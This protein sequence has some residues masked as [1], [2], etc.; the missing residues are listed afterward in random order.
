M[1]FRFI[2]VMGPTE[3]IDDFDVRSEGKKE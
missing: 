2:L 1:D 3:V